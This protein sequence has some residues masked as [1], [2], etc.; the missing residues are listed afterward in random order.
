M[1]KLKVYVCSFG[2][3]TVGFVD[4]EGAMHACARA[5]KTAFEGLARVSGLLGNRY[6][7]DEDKEALKRVAEFCN[8]NCLEFEVVDIGTM[9]FIKKLRLKVR[10]IKTP[11][12]SYGEKIFLG[13]PSEEDLSKMLENE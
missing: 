2:I 7:F 10:G 11:A 13:V 12:V 4:K 9:N 6:L 1:G 8:S 5:Q 3:P